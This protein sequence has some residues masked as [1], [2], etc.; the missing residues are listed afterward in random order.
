M[1]IHVIA[2]FFGVEPWKI[3]RVDT[4]RELIDKI[5][6][7]SGLKP[8]TSSYHQFEPQGVSGF[9][10]LRESHFSI[11]TWPEF[12]YAA[13]DVFSC[14][15]EETAFKAVEL[16][17]K[18]LKPKKIVKKIIRRGPVGKVKDDDSS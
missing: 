12:R 3:S 16:L 2:E 11:H 15:V 5:V 14:G 9:Y 6:L 8:I 7:E 13:V 18:D 17:K 4:L 1:G 10:L